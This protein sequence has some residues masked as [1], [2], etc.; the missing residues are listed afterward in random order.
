[1]LSWSFILN[2]VFEE[3]DNGQYLFVSL[4]NDYPLQT[5]RFINSAYQLRKKNLK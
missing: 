4:I 5:A 1:M 2:F 3:F